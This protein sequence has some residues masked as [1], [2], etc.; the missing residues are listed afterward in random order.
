MPHAY[1]LLELRAAGPM[2]VSE[3][4]QRL[5][6]DRTNVSRLCQRM[7]ARGE[8]L[9]AAHPQDGRAVLVRLSAKGQR[10]ADAVDAAS[11]Q[12]FQRVIER[13]DADADAVLHAL[14][15]RAQALR[16]SSA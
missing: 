11:A 6:I 13:L 9:R 16:T 3:L 7:Q 8:L 10:A 14:E 1:A 2:S 4:A 15:R 5:S 12:H